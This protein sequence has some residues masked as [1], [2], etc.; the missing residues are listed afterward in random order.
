[1]PDV[2]Y[3]HGNLREALLKRAAA[4]IADQ[5][6]EALS[7]R[8]L[9]QDLGVSHGAPARHFSDKAELLRTLATEGHLT[10][11]EYAFNASDQAGSDPLERYAAL[12]RAYVRF[13][14]DF[15]AYYK[16]GRH[17]EVT[18]QADAALEEAHHSRM[19]M[20]HDATRQA[21]DAGWLAGE[22]T[23]HALVFALATARGLAALLNDP[24]FR[25]HMSGIDPYVLID[26]VVRL[27]ID[28][29]RVRAGQKNPAGG[30]R[31]PAAQETVRGEATAQPSLRAK[32]FATPGAPE[33]PSPG[34][35]HDDGS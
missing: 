32:T 18:A 2:T 15:P 11:A 34:A 17:P 31:S 12:G 8:A 29:A 27:I 4:I 25:T 21:Q 7:L 14:L 5:G 33:A 35:T 20:L 30:S 10:L 26:E 23:D 16:T 19:A 6:V 3:H 1:M 13:S 9:A 28:P 22:Q 24:L